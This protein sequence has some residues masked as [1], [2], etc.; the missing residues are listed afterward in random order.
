MK[1]LIIQT[2]PIHTASTVLVNALY[3]MIP[4]ISHMNA[5]GVWDCSDEYHCDEDTFEDYIALNTP[6]DFEEIVVLKSHNTY[7]DYYMIKYSYHYDIY[8]VSSE[9][10]AKDVAG[11]MFPEEYRNYENLI[12]FDYEEINETE[13]YSIEDIVNCMYDKLS[14]TIPN[15]N[16]SKSGGVDRIR[17]M[18]KSYQEICGLVLGWCNSI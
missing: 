9:R 4:E 2:S 3:G 16:F 8:F 17:G 10:K 1:T 13:D 15:I 5:I 6:N 14:Q 11:Y 18:N 7:L 12:L